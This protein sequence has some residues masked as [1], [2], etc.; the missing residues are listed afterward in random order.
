MEALQ[1]QFIDYR[2]VVIP[3]HNGTFNKLNA[4][5]KIGIIYPALGGGALKR[6]TMDPLDANLVDQFCALIAQHQPML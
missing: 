1:L 4:E 3:Q 5:R 2:Y 6:Q